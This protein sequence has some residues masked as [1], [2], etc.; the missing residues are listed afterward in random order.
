MS[1]PVDLKHLERQAYLAYHGD[2]II[3]LFIGFV[4]IWVTI[5]LAIIPEMFIF[6]V[7]TFAALLPCYT[8]AKKSFTVPRIGYVEF[9]ASRSW[10]TKFLLLAINALLVFAVFVGMATWLLPPVTIFIVTNYLIITGTALA[11]IFGLTGFVTDINRFYGYGLVVFVGFI[12]THLFTLSF[13]T[14]LFVLSIVMIVHGSILL[15]RF[16]KKYPKIE[17]HVEWQANDQGA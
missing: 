1:K 9:S 4:I 2:G 8:S 12:L 13:V 17:G 15:L 14:P 10:D 5:L 16:I 11:A 3:D 6:L 7:G